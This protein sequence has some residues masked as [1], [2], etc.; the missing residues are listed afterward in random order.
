MYVLI[1]GLL[2]VAD[3][4][5]NPFGYDYHYDIELAATLDHN[6][7]KASQSL[8]SQDRALETDPLRQKDPSINKTWTD[9]EGFDEWALYQ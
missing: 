1:F 7:W 8:E 4:L 9:S 3:I 5:S 2:R 6:I